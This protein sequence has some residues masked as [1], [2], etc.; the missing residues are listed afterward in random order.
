MLKL[1]ESFPIRYSPIR[2]CSFQ[3]KLST[4]YLRRFIPIQNKSIHTTSS[5]L[6]PITI[7]N[8][9]RQRYSSKLVQWGTIAKSKDF[10]KKLSKWL[11]VLYLGFFIY[12]TTIIKKIYL[13][14]VELGNLERKLQN[15]DI[16]EF[17]LLKI[18][19]IKGQLRERDEK[20][21]KRYYLMQ[22][23]HK[24]K[25]FDNITLDVASQNNL[26]E[27]ILPA[28]DTTFFYDSKAEKYDKEINFEEKMIRMGKRR[29]WLTKRCEG[30][31]LEISC[32]TG[33]NIP[34]L[35][36]ANINS[37]TFLDSSNSMME[38]TVKK[39]KDKFPYFK[40]AAFV[41]GHVE[42]LPHLAQG[43]DQI[44]YDTI[45]EAF[46]LCSHKDPVNALKNMAFFLKPD[47]RIYLLEHGRGTNKTIN[48]IL[49][50]RSKKRLETWGC[51]WNLDIGE[52]LDDSGL[53]IVSEKRFHM[54]TTW[55][56]VAKRKGERAKRQETS[57]FQ[58]YIGSALDNNMLR[59]DTTD[60][61]KIL[62]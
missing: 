31:V 39:F 51:R 53:E 14:D 42:E 47:G 62:N 20:K 61:N 11:I 23:E 8:G 27:S 54:G 34:Y 35:N 49:D 50:K 43:K 25:N 30:D 40:N 13:R 3:N 15:G 33:R 6:K 26:N 52:I 22:N 2:L 7:K 55:C 56:I 12:G 9:S 45:I 38:V 46:G 44:Y 21:L 4:L 37:I 58:K 60:E 17:E 57:F 36:I 29:K 59:K 48:K 1:L 10:Q 24:I 19:E 16:N 18:K 41:V 28:R 5:F 32:G